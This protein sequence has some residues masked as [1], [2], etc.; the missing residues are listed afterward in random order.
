MK[1]LYVLPCIVPLLGVGAQ[2][3][4][5]GQGEA[6]QGASASP[7]VLQVAAPPWVFKKFPLETVA[8]MFEKSNPGIT[9]QLTRQSKWDVSTYIAAWRSGTTPVDV[10][11][12]GTGSMLAPVIAGHWSIPL[13]SLLTGKMAKD[14]FVGGFLAAGLYKKPGGGSYYPVLPFM[15]EL[16]AVAV[17]VPLMEKAGLWK[18]G[19]PVPMPSWNEQAIIGWFK[20]LKAVSANSAFVEQ[21]SRE[22]MQYDFLAPLQAMQG[23]FT[24]PNGKGFDHYGKLP[25]LKAYYG[26]GITRFQSAMPEILKIADRSQ[27]IPVYADMEQYLD[28]LQEYLPA[29]AFDRISV[30]DGLAKIEAASKNLDFTNLRAN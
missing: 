24:A 25:V 9:V 8:K 14:K 21:W 17:N 20:K 4:A 26:R 29:I 6:K 30:S 22:Y 12:G 11:V 3:F 1:K 18:N 19:A 7:K 28:I 10:Y 23:S 16:A 27:P 15:G 2:L 5:G 13:D